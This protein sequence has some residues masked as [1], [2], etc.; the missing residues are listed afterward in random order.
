MEIRIAM[1]ELKIQIPI[2]NGS[3]NNNLILI[4]FFGTKIF[5]INLRSLEKSILKL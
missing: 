2:V 3:L 5:H 1:K 4:T